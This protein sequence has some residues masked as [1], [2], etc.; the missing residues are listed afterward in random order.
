MLPDQVSREDVERLRLI[1]FYFVTSTPADR[2]ELFSR[3]IFGLARDLFC[4]VWYLTTQRTIFC[5]FC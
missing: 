5:F 4:T 2:S 3:H 1:R